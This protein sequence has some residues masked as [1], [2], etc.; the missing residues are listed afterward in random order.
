MPDAFILNRKPAF[1]LHSIP[2]LRLWYTSPYPSDFGH[3]Q[4]LLVGAVCPAVREQKVDD[5]TDDWE[6]EHDQAPDDLVDDGTVRLEDLDC[7]S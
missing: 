5:H 3:L 6:E 2:E 1:Q 7:W 4:N